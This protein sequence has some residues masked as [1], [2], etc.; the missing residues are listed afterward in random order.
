MGDDAYCNSIWY[1]L[2]SMATT[3]RLGLPYLRLRQSSPPMCSAM[4]E[5]GQFQMGLEAFDKCIFQECR[6]TGSSCRG[7]TGFP[8]WSSGAGIDSYTLL[9]SSIL[10]YA[11]A[12]LLLLSPVIQS[13]ILAVELISAT[14]AVRTSLL[15][16]RRR[17]VIIIKSSHCRHCRWSYLKKSPACC[18]KAYKPLM[19]NSAQPFDCQVL[20]NGKQ[21][22][23]WHICSTL[24]VIQDAKCTIYVI[25]LVFVMDFVLV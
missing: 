14:A 4:R 10:T 24:Y 17:R 8:G 22:S 12:W 11:K 15:S 5:S 18:K 2:R 19:L 3:A 6:G 13:I 25:V 1:L 9:K 23:S 16:R 21:I 7:E 20:K